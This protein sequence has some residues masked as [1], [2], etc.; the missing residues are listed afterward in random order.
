MNHTS[1]S[2]IEELAREKIDG[3]SYSEIRTE[4]LESGMTEGEA[5]SLIRKVDERVL[6]EST[7]LGDRKRAQQWYRF[8]F[9]LAIA[10]LILSIAYNAGTLFENLPA[11]VLYTPFFAGILVMIYGKA[12]QRKQSNPS[13]KGLGTIRRRRPYK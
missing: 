11:L 5:L 3:K 4:L 6:K 2:K 7:N 10:G 12:I 13:E 1:E 8:G 9:V